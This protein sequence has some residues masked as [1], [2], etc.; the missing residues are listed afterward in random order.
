MYKNRGSKT[1]P[2]SSITVSP[3]QIGMLLECPRCLWLYFR[4]GLKRPSGIFP[5]LPGGFDRLFKTYFDGY[6]EKEEL[7]PELRGLGK[8]TLYTDRAFLD[9]WRNNWKGISYVFTELDLTL[10]GAIDDLLINEKGEF[11]PIDFKTRGYPL[12]E[13]TAAHY[14]TQLDLYALLFEK[15]GYPVAGYGYLLFFWPKE[16][17]QSSADFVTELVK[18]KLSPQN[19]LGILEEVVRIVRDGE[20]KAHSECEFC[21]FREFSNGE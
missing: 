17:A 12:K 4:E 7:P 11:V 18:L 19:G 14:Q 15:N 1:T 3:S 9:V 16:Y 5:S 6:R 10:K 2:K 21:R 20:P 13:D 8:E